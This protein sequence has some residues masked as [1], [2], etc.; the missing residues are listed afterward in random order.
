MFIGEI[1]IYIYSKTQSQKGG[2]DYRGGG[3]YRGFPEYFKTNNAHD[4]KCN[5]T[6]LNDLTA[7]SQDKLPYLLI[8][9]A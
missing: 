1:E 7:I 2:G 6:N 9:C 4:D 8:K 5:I 3:G